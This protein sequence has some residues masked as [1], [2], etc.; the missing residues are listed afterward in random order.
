M[1]CVL[2]VRG[3]LKEAAEKKRLEKERK[4]VPD[5]VKEKFKEWNKWET[6]FLKWSQQEVKS[7]LTRIR[8]AKDRNDL[9]VPKAK[10]KEIKYEKNQKH[11][12]SE[13]RDAFNLNESIFSCQI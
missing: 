2:K 11:L 1:R 4:E 5:E 8:M 13:F 10:C 3:R 6:L 9:V 12:E 7:G